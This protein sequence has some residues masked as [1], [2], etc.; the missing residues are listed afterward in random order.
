[1][2]S[3]N[4]IQ[5]RRPHLSMPSHCGGRVLPHEFGSGGGLDIVHN[6]R[7]MSEPEAGSA[8]SVH[9]PGTWISTHPSSPGDGEQLGSNS[10][11]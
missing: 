7:Q 1:M 4:P 2:T 5:L 3:S 11:Q 6:R 10:G 9:D 8:G